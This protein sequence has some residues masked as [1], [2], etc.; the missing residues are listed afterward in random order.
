VSYGLQVET[1]YSLVSIV[2]LNYNG[3][4]YLMNC[5]SSVLATKYPNFEVILVDNASTDSS[6]ES[7][8]EAFG[9]DSRLKVVKNNLNLGF[10]GGNNVGFSY[11][12]GDYIVFLNNDTVV[13]PDWLVYLVN[14]LQN[15]P[16]IGLAQSMILTI[17]GE[18]IQTAGWLFSN[19]L[20]RKYQLCKDK[21]SNLKFEP[22]FEV[23]FVCGASMIIRRDVVEEMGLFEPK[24]PFFYDDTLLSLKTWLSQKRVVTVSASR[25]R[26][27]GGA[28][29]VWNIQFTTYHLLK[30]NIC[31]LFDVYS[32]LSDLAGALLINAFYLSTNSLF[33][34][35]RKNIAAILGNINGLAWGLSNFRYLWQNRLN[36]LNKQKI[37]PE[38][39]NEKFLR[40]KLPVSFY[41]IPSRLGADYFTFE[42]GKYEKA[43][44]QA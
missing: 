20:I 5:I 31:L 19:Y 29:N 12:K 15:D 3:K 23:S 39:L 8:Q 28:T 36:H 34:L 11:S 24:M 16:T 35:K 13:D 7:V 42:V 22:I 37:T 41:L 14:A 33:C 26:H 17:D 30:S 18:K 27:A 9:A 25:I 6:L 2:I 40:L 32:K 1:N 38:K 21:P 44:M 4:N 43:L 10:S